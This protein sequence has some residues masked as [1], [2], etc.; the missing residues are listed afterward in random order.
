MLW[1][2]EFKHQRSSTV[3]VADQERQ[4]EILISARQN[5]T[6]YP[7]AVSKMRE[8]ECTTS[9]ICPLI[10]C[11][12]SYPPS[13]T[14]PIFLGYKTVEWVGSIWGSKWREGSWLGLWWDWCC[15]FSTWP[16]EIR[17]H[18]AHPPP[19]KICWG[20]KNILSTLLRESVSSSSSLMCRL[21][22]PKEA[23]LV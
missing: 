11:M 3:P 8:C 15:P 18:R 19:L 20:K 22:A 16:P 6:A 13:L 10:T 5:E 12:S 7:F 4:D 17:S 1:K 23:A 9:A 2:G 14:S 21:P